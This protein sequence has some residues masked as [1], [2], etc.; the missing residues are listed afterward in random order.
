MGLSNRGIS[1][2]RT[3]PIVSLTDIIQVIPI[4]YKPSEKSKSHEPSSRGLAQRMVALQ[5]DPF[6]FRS[7]LAECRL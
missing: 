5:G 7:N 6:H 1:G 2:R 4:H 3:L